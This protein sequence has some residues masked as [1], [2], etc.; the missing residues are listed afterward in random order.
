[1]SDSLWPHGC[2]S[3]GSSVH[4][5]LQAR[6]LEWL[7]CPPP[8]DLPD[9]GIQ[10][11][12]PMSP[13]LAADSL[14]LCHLA[15]PSLSTKFQIKREEKKYWI[16]YRTSQVEPVVKNLP[17]NSGDT[18]EVGLSPG[19]EDPLEE[20]MATHSSL[21]AWRIPWTEEPGGPRSTGSQRVRYSWSNLAHTHAYRVRVSPTKVSQT[22]CPKRQKW[23]HT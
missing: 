17:A 1:M 23:E 5:I 20:G 11:K 21:L 8:G 13:A 12:S 4:R 10:P 6:I 7:P 14:P 2:S 15:S 3:P 9:P 18:R 22:H 19:P 16:V